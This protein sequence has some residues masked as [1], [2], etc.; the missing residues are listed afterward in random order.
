MVYS[1]N[2]WILQ[3]KEYW[4]Y[5]NETISAT[6]KSVLLPQCRW[7]WCCH[8][9]F[10]ASSIGTSVSAAMHV[11]SLAS[12]S[13]GIYEGGLSNT[14]YLE[15]FHFH[16]GTK[17]RIGSEHTVDGKAYAMEMHLVHYSEDYN[18]VSAAANITGGL[19]VLGMFIEIGNES[20]AFS[21]L[22]SQF[23]QTIRQTICLSPTIHH[24]VGDMWKRC[25]CLTSFFSD[26]RYVP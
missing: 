14:Y 13:I 9:Y 16:W 10:I 21:K 1:S 3:S 25:C 8:L 26:C 11:M 2:E 12:M 20:A 5:S 6:S 4:H 24:I 18:N 22:I 15:Q 19:A 17:D 23:G 7:L